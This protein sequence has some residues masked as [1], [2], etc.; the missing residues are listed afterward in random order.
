MRN[1]VN[2]KKQTLKLSPREG[3]PHILDISFKMDVVSECRCAPLCGLV[4]LADGDH[5]LLP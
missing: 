1:L 4:L 2:L 5:L 3:S